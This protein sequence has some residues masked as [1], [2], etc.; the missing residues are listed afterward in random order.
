MNKSRYETN[1]IISQCIEYVDTNT[2]PEINHGGQGA[3]YKLDKKDCGIA[4]VKKYFDNTD[5]EDI[6]NEISGLLLVKELI[7]DVCPN[8]LYLYHYSYDKRYIIV[9]YCDG[10][11]ESLFLKN[12]LPENVFKSLLIQVL[13][14]IYAMQ[15]IGL[16]HYD[17]KYRNIFYK[18]TTD[19]HISYKIN[20]I[21][22]NVPTYGYLVLIADFGLIKV[23]K[24]DMKKVIDEYYYY[25]LYS[26]NILSIIYTVIKDKIN[27][28]KYVLLNKLNEYN[29]IKKKVFSENLNY[30]KRISKLLYISIENNYIDK[31]KLTSDINTRLTQNNRYIEWI[32]KYDIFLGNILKKNML[33]PNVL[34]EY[35]HYL[36]SDIAKSKL[37]I[38]SS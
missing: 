14:A 34:E 13:C 24:D 16:V 30:K 2:L 25:P 17:L 28:D 31:N 27:I 5:I 38:I 23:I 3:V 29:K 19:E 6:K 35:F 7:N 11:L 22:Y 21:I 9:E 37:F 26:H 8:F 18:K 4:V 33:I 20:N 36:V 15:T 10:D 12:E 32:T 1:K